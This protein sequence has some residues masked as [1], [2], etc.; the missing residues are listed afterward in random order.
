MIKLK[1][2]TLD[3]GR[4]VFIPANGYMQGAHWMYWV[5]RQGVVYSV[6]CH[7]I[8]AGYLDDVS[9]IPVPNFT[10]QM[11]HAKCAE[12]ILLEV[13]PDPDHIVMPC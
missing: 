13:L 5:A 4:T 11:L 7:S 2:Q 8:N 12:G 3:L 1:L 9:V 6:V 10:L